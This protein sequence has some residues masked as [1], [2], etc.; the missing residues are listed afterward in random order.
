MSTRHRLIMY[1]RLT[2]RVG[3]IVDVRPH[4]VP[5]VLGLA[6]ISH[7][8]EPGETELTDDQARAIAK[9]LGIRINLSRY[10]Y[11]LETLVT[12]QDRLWA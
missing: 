6:G 2:D 11:Y 9:L 8:D 1:E 5:Q 4:F 12:A 10:V 7:G 3:G